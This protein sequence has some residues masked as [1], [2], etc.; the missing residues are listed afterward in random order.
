MH[1][2]AVVQGLSE[3]PFMVDRERWAILAIGS[4]LGNACVTNR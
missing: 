1:D 4:G 2:D 3:L